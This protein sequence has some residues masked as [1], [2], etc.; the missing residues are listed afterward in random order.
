MK[1]FML[2]VREDLEKIGK[3]SDK[4]RF[5]SSPNMVEWIDALVESGNYIMGTPLLIEGRYVGKDY[6]QTDGPFIES[7]EGISGF[8][9]I[10]AENLE[11]A[12]AIAQSCPMV[13]IG[14]A[15]R[16]VRPIID[17]PT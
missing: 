15:I 10:W 14:M 2:I 5:A 16:E 4:E 1:K 9:L 12:T 11:Q 8:D 7:N 13:S 3:M 17:M 6:V